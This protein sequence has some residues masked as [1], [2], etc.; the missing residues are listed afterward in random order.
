MEI[1]RYEY[2]KI[3]KLTSEHTNK[4]YIGS[5]CKKLLSQRLASHNN[6]YKQWKKGNRIGYMYSFKLFDLGLVQ[7][8]LLEACPCNTKDELLSRERYWM[9]QNQ[10]ILVNKNK[11]ILI[12]EEYKIQN[13]KYYEE[14]KQII[15]ERNKKYRNTNKDKIKEWGAQRITCICGSCVG[16]REKARHEQSKKHLNFIKNT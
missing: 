1:N 12:D 5:T 13:I 10:D 3:Y 16:L 14:N 9:E 15:L 7:I 6:N 11:S 2:G 8:T 4:I